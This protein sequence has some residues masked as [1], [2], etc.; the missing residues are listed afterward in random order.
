MQYNLSASLGTIL[1]KQGG[2]LVGTALRAQVDNHLLII[3]PGD[4]DVTHARRINWARRPRGLITQWLSVEICLCSLVT[5]RRRDHLTF[6]DYFFLTLLLK[7]TTFQN[8]KLT[9]HFI[10]VITPWQRAVR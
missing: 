7:S 3:I 1:I 9:V 10:F 8:G 5:S 4:P 6:G 2:I